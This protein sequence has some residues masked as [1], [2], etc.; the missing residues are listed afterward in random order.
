MDY[1]KISKR[2]LLFLLII[3]SIAINTYFRFFPLLLPSI[4]RFAKA[5][6]YAG[7]RNELRQDL[8]KTY[9]AIA[10]N[11][12]EKTL[13]LLLR[14]HIKE[15]REEVTA[16]IA[17]KSKELKD[18][19]LDDKGWPYLLE[20]DS[21]RWQRRIE[22]FVNTGHFGT[23]RINGQ[24]F[25]KL[26]SAPLGAKIEPLK[27]HFYTGVFLYN[28]LHSMNRNLSIANCLSFH[29]VLFSI[30]MLISVF[31]ICNLLG[32]SVFGSF[33]S[34]LFIGLS[35]IVLS[36][37]GFAWFD[38]DVYNI[39]MPLAAI[40]A[41]A[42]SFKQK[43]LLKYYFYLGLSG[44]LIGI[45]SSLWAAW[46]LVF[47]ILLFG[48]FLYWLEI[49]IYDRKR[50]V[51]IRFKEFLICICIFIFSSFLSIILISGFDAIQR[52]FS[53]IFS[54]F[55]LRQ[56]IAV[57]NFWPNLA[58]SVA[59]LGRPG[60]E[61][62]VA[63]LGSDILLYA[64]ILG[65][66]LFF[67]FQ[68]QRICPKEQRFLFFALFA[69]FVAALA[70]T[71]FG[72]RFVLLLVA[73]LGISLG[74][75]WDSF[76]DIL[77]Q[78]RLNLISKINRKIKILIIG[79]IFIFINS[80]PV[81]SASKFNWGH[82]MND[83]NW[84]MLLKIKEVTPEDAIIHTTWEPGDFIM[85][86]ADRATT[87]DP[88]WQYN[89][90]PYWFDRAL[91]SENEDEA[92]SM[93]RM[94]TSGG[95]RAFEELT[96]SLGN[97]KFRAMA[98]INKVFLL[99]KEED[100]KILLTSYSIDEIQADKILNLM[101]KT[102]RPAYLLVYYRM[103]GSLPYIRII[104]NWD[105]NRLNLWQQ[106]N[107]LSKDDFINYAKE[108]FSYSQ[109]QSREIYHSLKLIDK[110]N[111]LNWVG[112]SSG[113]F[114]T[115]Y[116]KE[117]IEGDEKIIF[118]D[119]GLV[120]DRE[121]LQAYFRD[122]VTASSKAAKYLIFVKKDEIKENINNA[123]DDMYSVLVSQDNNT[124]RATLFSSSLRRT[125]FFKLFFTNGSGLKY[126]KLI[127]RENNK[128]GMDNIYLFKINL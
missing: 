108:K 49:M 99:K 73:P 115:P 34:S 72:V 22:N 80:I 110:S 109:E 41:L 38:T 43:H 69:W 71:Y 26:M 20:T 101:R 93:L 128:D 5:E 21:Y 28:F 70:L 118:F 63:H 31:F 89:P 35:N 39:L 66:L 83:A 102:I 126:F 84:N 82:L 3:L 86:V 18:Y 123:G 2:R 124:Y 14:E 16:A 105:F 56:G 104:G 51:S 127:H 7:L 74:I 122:P 33:I 29:P 97:N 8:S 114:Y 46:W 67:I 59:E 125:L 116:S 79:C 91:L 121:N 44:L 58:F 95:N 1:Y 30:L 47:Y 50:N 36:R 92:V 103:V 78:N 53:D 40:S 75:L 52:P 13:S 11:I 77:N 60:I 107:K 88:S 96:K 68:K 120:V 85:T 45:Y 81:Y 12:S 76:I 106:F 87:H 25:D 48:I 42:C 62:L 27:L 32:M 112:N 24:E 117:V 65:L 55:A 37:T 90:I 113:R 111:I 19:F 6:V 64:G 94:L 4:N 98:A 119:N 17:K 61:D 15:E 10:G 100:I 23:D 57:D 54:Y 9:P